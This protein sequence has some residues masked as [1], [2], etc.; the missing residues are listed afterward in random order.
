MSLSHY[1]QSRLCHIEAILCRSDPKLA[2]MV[3]MFDGL[4]AGQRAVSSGIDATMHR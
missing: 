2:G 3:S 1:E 4:A